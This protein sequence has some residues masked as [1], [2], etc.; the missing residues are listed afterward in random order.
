MR[1]IHS[2]VLLANV[3]DARAR[4]FIVLFTCDAIARSILITIVPLQAYALLGGARAVS[5]AYFSVAFVGLAAS[6]T[7]PV[8]LHRMRRRWVLT[9]GAGVQIASALLFALGTK[10]SLVAGL[11]LQMLGMAILEI[12][13]NLYLLDHIPRRRL[14]H[15]EPRRLL[16][17]GTAFAAGPWVGVYLHREVGENLTYVV[18][19]LATLTLLTFFWALR[20]ADNPS[21]RGAT[22]PPPSPL[23]FV[24]RFASQ[25][26]LVLSWVLALGRNGWWV[27]YFIYV[28]IYVANAGYRPDIGGALVSLG[29]AP[30]LL[31]RVWGR[32]GQSIGT[33][34]LL[35]IGYGVTGLASL[36]A[37]A[38]AGVPPLCMALICFAAFSATMIDGAGNVPFLRAVHPYER[39]AMTA[40][41]MTFRYVGSLVVPG[42]LA[43]VLWLLPLPFV[44]IAGGLMA[45]VMA[46]LS[47]YIPRRL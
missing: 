43:L 37:G 20:L 15:F 42:T 33:R 13:I 18:A 4:A 7:V 23:G 28:P 30:M 40:V 17:A 41:F 27:M 26:R 14:S 29:L 21:L 16:F 22:A 5:V 46:G 25:P 3:E 44:F 31:V 10:A 6:L 8:V 38:A 11:A 32:I 35:S 19:A 12:V 24:R 36:A 34:N 1:R 2:P 45:L 47:R 39:E 9:V